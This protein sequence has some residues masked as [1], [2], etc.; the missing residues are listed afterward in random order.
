[1]F[2]VLFS[3]I[4]KNRFGGRLLGLPACPSCGI[5]DRTLGPAAGI[6]GDGQAAAVREGDF[7]NQ[8]EAGLLRVSVM[9]PF[10][11]PCISAAFRHAITL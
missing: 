2:A 6:R 8:Q 5:P 9:P 4:Q 3:A 11:H 10:C 7:R 1:M